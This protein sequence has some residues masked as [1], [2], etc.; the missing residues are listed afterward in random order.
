MIERRRQV[1]STQSISSDSHTKS[2][3]STLESTLHA[4]FPF[5]HLSSAP[6]D[7]QKQAPEVLKP[8]ALYAECVVQVAPTRIPINVAPSARQ[9]KRQ[10]AAEMRKPQVYNSAG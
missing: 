5:K 6:D 4:L 1:Y 3:S 7:L 8:G 10:M 2:P 9:R